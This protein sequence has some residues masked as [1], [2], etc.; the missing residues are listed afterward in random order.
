M[1]TISSTTLIHVIQWIYQ[2]Y[3]AYYYLHGHYPTVLHQL[4][5]IRP[6]HTVYANTNNTNNANDERLQSSYGTGNKVITTIG[7]L[8][9]LQLSWKLLIYGISQ[10]A[11]ECWIRIKPLL[12]QTFRHLRDHMKKTL[13]LPSRGVVDGW[14]KAY[15]YMEGTVAIHT[16]VTKS[17]DAETKN[18]DCDD[19]DPFS[20][21]L[22]CGICR[23]SGSSFTNTTSSKNNNNSPILFPSCSIKCGHVFCWYCIQQWLTYYDTKCPICR[24]ICTANDIQL[25]YNY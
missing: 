5:R 20:N 13:G 19:N 21:V 6:V 25:L 17:I 4:F 24:T 15:I 8:I 9:M 12:Q 14:P 2:F 3:V 22:V 16:S 1:P 18:T 23:N 7:T 11:L 10:P